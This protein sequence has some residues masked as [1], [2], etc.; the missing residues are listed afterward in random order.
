MPGKSP[1]PP[2]S[3]NMNNLGAG[4]GRGFTLL[5]MVLAMACTALIVSVLVAV[6]IQVMKTSVDS[7]KEAADARRKGEEHAVIWRMLRSVRW[8]PESLN[9]GGS[10]PWADEPGRLSLWSDDSESRAPGPVRWT[11]QSGSGGMNIEWAG[12]ADSG[13]APQKA[14]WPDVVQVR[15]DVLAM[16][17]AGD[18]IWS[19]LSDLPAGSTFRPSG[20]RLR[21]QWRGQVG[22]E[23]LE[24]VP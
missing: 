9:P 4:H 19:N 17:P 3:G 22:E 8:S 7:A 11:L 18:P 23:D 5:E 1:R 20:F 14:I 12:L 24:W 6:W 21:I 10:L 16:A 15:M 13:M 2:L